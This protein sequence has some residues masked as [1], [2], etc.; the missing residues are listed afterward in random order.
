MADQ[1]RHVVIIDIDGLRRDVLYNTLAEDSLREDTNR[2]LP[3]LSKIVGSLSLEKISSP[4]AITLSGDYNVTQSESIVVNRCVTAFPSYTYPC[5]TSIFT[6]LF[7]KHHGITA[8]F[9]F[10][11]MGRSVG[12]KGKTENYSKFEALSFFM[13]EGSGSRMMNRGT[14][15]IYDYLHEQYKCAVCYNLFVSQ[16]KGAVNHIV[17]VFPWR[18]PWRFDGADPKTIDWIIPDIFNQTQFITERAADG[19]GDYRENFDG[20]MM[21]DAIRYL[22]DFVRH[23]HAPP[24]LFTLYFGGH[25][26]QAHIH[27]RGELQDHGDLIAQRDYLINTV[28]TQLGRFL[29]TWTSLSK[30]AP[31]DDTLFVICS[32]HGHTG[33]ELNDAKRITRAEVKALLKRCGYDV[34]GKGEYGEIESSCNAIITVTAAAAQIYIRRGIFG[35]RAR[36][37]KIDWQEQPTFKD[38]RELLQEFSKA[39]QGISTVNNFLANAL[40]YILFK[41]Y[42]KNVYQ[43]YHYDQHR[44]GDHIA[45][46][47]SNFGDKQGYILAVDRLQEMYGDNSGD[48]ILL[49]N[50][51]HDFRFEKSH[52]MRSTHGSLYPS[53]SYVPLIFATPFNRK[54]MKKAAAGSYTSGVV[55]QAR[56]YDITPTIVGQFGIHPPNLDGKALF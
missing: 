20:E 16:N 48:I 29:R 15:T 23:K 40:D 18:L 54:L 17:G 42:E 4:D 36:G 13:N 41:D 52:R 22:E 49:I 5:Q 55:Q 7:P 14:Q 28:D 46:L 51:Q 37:E 10:D 25:D 19:I 12:A 30:F 45:A 32:D 39:N 43:V 9:H 26:H 53:D 31:L 44:A 8:N 2:R 56:I 21:D 47:K 1:I 34:L 38:L 6:G 50:Y 27:L 24:N 35:Y 11:R 3:N 33:A